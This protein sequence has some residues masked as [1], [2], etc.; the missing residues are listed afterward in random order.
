MTAGADRRTYYPPIDPHETG[1]LDVG[2]GQR[3]AWEVS[4][5]DDGVPVVFV[6]GGPGG[7]TNPDQR[8]Y[9]DPEHYRIVLFNQR[10][11]GS[12]TPHVADG[13]DLSVNT[14]PALIGDMELLREHLGIGS[15]IVF[16][17]SW[18]STLALAYA[19]THP[20]RVRALVLRGIFLLRDAEIDWYYRGGAGHLFPEKWEEFLAPIP[21]DRRDEDPVAVYHDLLHSPDEDVAVRAAVAWSTWEGATS[22]LLPSPSRLDQT[23]DPRFALA[24]A[25]IENHYFVHGGFLEPGQLLR[26]IDRI[27]DIPGVIV[28][29]RYDVVTPARSALDLHRAWPSSTLHVVDDAGHSAAE[30]G[31]VH[32]LVEAMDALRR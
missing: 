21:A 3:L 9:F 4:G 14:T 26:D 12:S 11:C 20:D 10:G 17:G 2:D 5:A 27:A 30:P 13:A 25:R 31:I 32:H 28:Q 18:G 22:S 19:Q 29:G 15:W 7:G 6:H 1:L 8:R 24:F 23:A 16:G